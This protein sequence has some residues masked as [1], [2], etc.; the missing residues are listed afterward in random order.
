VTAIAALETG[1]PPKPTA[2]ESKIMMLKTKLAY[3]RNE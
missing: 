2:T 3:E 1:I